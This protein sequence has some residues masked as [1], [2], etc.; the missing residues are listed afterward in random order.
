MIGPWHHGS[1]SSPWNGRFVGEVNAQWPAEDDWP[2]ARAQDTELH[3]NQHGA[4]AWT[5]PQLDQAESGVTYD[6]ADPATTRGGAAAS[7]RRP[8]S[9]AAP[10]DQRVADA[11]DDVLVFTTDPLDADLE[12]TGRIRA[13]LFAATDGPSTDWGAAA[14]GRREGRV[15]QHRR[16]DHPHEAPPTGER[17]LVMRTVRELTED[18]PP[19][20]MVDGRLGAD[21][22][23]V[24]FH[25]S[26]NWSW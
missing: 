18:R 25:S 12:I 7:S 10:F 11:R 22:Q 1:L 9:L 5:A 15:A 3:V 4:L 13:T 6:P 24:T 26:L 21:D 19:T 16:R 14:R 20:V 8:T 2:L 23:G 17:H